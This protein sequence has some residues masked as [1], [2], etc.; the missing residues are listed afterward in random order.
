MHRFLASGP[1]VLCAALWIPQMPAPRA[2]VNLQILAGAPVG[3]QPTTCRP[4]GVSVVPGASIQAAV[5]AQVGPATF[6]LKAGTHSISASI[7]PK[8][9]HTFIGELGAVLDGSGWVTSDDTAAAF[10]AHNQN[11][12]DVTIRNLVIRNMPQN[13]IHAFKDFADR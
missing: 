1:A 6:C 10:R 2:P 5:S 8:S 11:I 4:A 13:G 9:G 7:V 12:D 3:P